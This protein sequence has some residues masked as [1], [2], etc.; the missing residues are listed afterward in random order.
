MEAL[1]LIFVMRSEKFSNH[2]RHRT[3]WDAPTKKL[4]L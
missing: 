4:E 2:F 1:F 3:I